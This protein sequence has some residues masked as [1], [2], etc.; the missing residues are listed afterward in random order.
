MSNPLI[1]R[2]V[3][4]SIALLFIVTAGL[5][6]VRAQ[7]AVDYDADDDGLIE[8]EWLE[9]LDAVRWDLDGDGFA[10]DEANAGRYSAAFP[11]AMEGMGCADGCNGYELARDL[12]FKSAGS[13]AAGAVNEKWTS[14]NGWL[15]IGVNEKWSYA[16]LEG[17]GHT[18]SRLYIHRKGDTQPEAIGLFGHSGGT[19]SRVGVIDVDI[20]AGHNVVGGL[21]GGNGGSIKSSF[22]SGKV[23]SVENGRVGG[24]VGENYSKITY[25]YS[26][27]SVFGGSSGGLV[28]WNDGNIASS[29]SKSEVSGV[30]WVGGIAGENLGIITGSYADSIISG[31][32]DGVAA[33]L[34]GVNYGRILSSYS[35]GNVSDGTSVGGFV[36]VN[37]SKIVSSY[38]TGSVSGRKSVGGLVGYNEGTIKYAYST[39]NVSNVENGTVV[40]G[41]AGINHGSGDT[42]ASYWNTETSEQ[43]I[44][45]GEGSVVGVEGKTTAELQEPTDYTGIYADWLTDFDNTDEDFDETT[46]VDGVWD[47]GT[48]SQYPELKVD[49][50]NSGNASWWEFGPQH[51]R[52]QPTATPTPI[53]TDTPTPTATAT[54][55]AT[56]TITPTP[57]ETA[58]PTST[59][60]PTETPTMTPT[61]TDT[62]APTATSTHTAVPTDTPA[63][64]STPEPTAP[65]AP[66]T[67]TPQVVVVV[68]TATPESNADAEM[69]QADAPS[70]SRCN[71]VGAMPVGAAAA[72]LLLLLAPL[73]IIGGVKQRC[74]KRGS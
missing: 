44:G 47:F 72:N 40:G 46:G 58:T 34:A 63:P 15:P 36:G 60:I 8:I 69:P 59:P 19:I 18:I 74:R 35:T 49:I 27:A 38:S 31:G 70:S 54:A 56:P 23:V 20:V 30:S 33:G 41:F 2:I 65:P 48:S 62:P 55:T 53:A 21:V 66:L 73:G 7:S 43:T 57:T 3:A 11:D 61:A 37:L 26:N 16:T 50:D 51:G 32:E 67:Q 22:S 17:N 13:Y 29:Y 14:G 5:N 39:G 1:A 24:L 42:L 25:N 64:T 10:D 6:V 52:P 68:V 28:G 4:L 9:Q 45:V 12:D 71:S